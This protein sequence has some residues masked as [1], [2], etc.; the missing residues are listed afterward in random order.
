MKNNNNT[1]ATDNNDDDVY[2][3][4]AVVG[5]RQN[6]DG[7]VD[8]L[9]KWKGYSEEE[10]T[11]EPESNLNAGSLEL[12][13]EYCKSYKL[14]D[15]DHTADK[16][17]EE[18]CF[19]F[20][21]DP[22]TILEN[23]G[24]NVASTFCFK[25]VTGI[26]H[27]L[28]ETHCVDLEQLKGSDLFKR[29]MIRSPDGLLQHYV[30]SNPVLK[31]NMWGFWRD[32]NRNGQNGHQFRALVNLVGD[33]EEKTGANSSGFCNS[34]PNRAKKIWEKVSAPYLKN[35]SEED[36]FI[37][38]DNDDSDEGG[39]EVR[40]NPYYASPDLSEE[41][42]TKQYLVDLKE[43]CEK[44]EEDR[45]NDTSSSLSIYDSDIDEEECS[46]ESSDESEEEDPWLKQKEDEL[47]QKREKRR[48]SQ[49]K[50]DEHSEDESIYQSDVAQG[51]KCAKLFA[52]SDDDDDDDDDGDDDE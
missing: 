17:Y 25:K 29:F 6:G 50:P 44:N 52:A 46:S 7:S 9:I 41:E 42:E 47:K 26:K 33:N 3:V 38:D 19:F 8:Y 13:K 15:D 27:H 34:F 35:D 49:T 24:F 5:Y 28:R 31:N 45:R 40:G 39:K 36:E 21:N 32:S 43:R 51:R 37:N 11:W 14:S 10:N 12:A 2:D 1:V 30:R 16:E 4:E 23:I 20:E 48:R 22:M 18:D